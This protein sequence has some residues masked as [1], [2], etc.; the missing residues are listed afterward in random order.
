MFVLL[1]LAA[2]PPLPV[3]RLRM[4]ILDPF[5]VVSSSLWYCVLWRRGEACVVLSE[6]TNRSME[7]VLLNLDA[8]CSLL[9]STVCVFRR[10]EVTGCC[11]LVWEGEKVEL[12]M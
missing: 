3:G 8:R 9:F 12:E 5:G 10:S 11:P 2:T 6:G 7:G 4:G 1:L